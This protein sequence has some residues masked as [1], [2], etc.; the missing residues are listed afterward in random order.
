[1]SSASP[2]VARQPD[3]QLP[4]AAARAVKSRLLHRGSFMIRKLLCASLLVAFFVP[5]V[6]AADRVIVAIAGPMVGTSSSVGVQYRVGVAAAVQALPGGKLLGREVVLN[7][8]DDRCNPEIAKAVAYEVVQSSPA[9]VIGHSC[10]DSTIA[11]APVYAENGLLQITPASSNPRVTEMG[12]GTL[13]RMIGRDD[14][15]GEIAA[16]RLATAHGDRRIG[17]LYF[18]GTYSRGL[19]DVTI[20]ALA[21]RGIEPVVVIEAVSSSPSYLDEIGRFEAAGAEV[22][23]LV[24]GGLDSAVF[25]RQARQLGAGFAV[26]SSDTLVS[27]TFI[28]AAGVAGE[29][30]PFT[31]PP[32]AANLPS[33]A[34]VIAEIEASGHE[35]A[36]YTLLA[37]AA[38]EVWFEGVRRA[39]TFGARE[40]ATALRSGP[41][42]TVLGPVSFDERGD[43]T[44]EYPPF[45]W[46]VWRA[47]ERV[48]AD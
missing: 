18:P 47:G 22:L 2:E 23:Y 41:V 17:V 14:R 11:A 24:G 46:F 45:T 21:R 3:R 34:Q 25:L 27:K 37:Y 8:Y 6:K 10:S 31:F 9:V 16:E 44:T 43:I 32:D 5:S 35:A 42:K 26:L 29:E 12:I 13:F 15:Q 19:T 48:P 4:W 36:G 1:M 39:N 20:A 30:V 33:S 28:D 7:T 38:A 40:V